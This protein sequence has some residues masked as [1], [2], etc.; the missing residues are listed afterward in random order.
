MAKIQEDII[1]SKDYEEG[2]HKFYG[3]TLCIIAALLFGLTSILAKYSYRYDATPIQI[4][5]FRITIAVPFF[6]ILLG[7]K[8]KIT[9]IPKLPRKYILY[10]A[11]AGVLGYYATM[12]F[13]FQA[14]RFIDAGLE[15][16]IFYTHPLFVIL[17]NSF[18]KRRPPSS[19]EIF[20]L[21]L[22]QIAIYLMLGNIGES[23]D[24]LKG[25]GFAFLASLVWG[26]YTILTHKVAK[27]IGSLSYLTY[28]ATFGLF[29]IATHF[30]ITEGLAGLVAPREL[31]ILLFSLAFFCTFVPY[32]VYTEGLKIIGANRASLIISAS[33]IITIILSFFILGETMT[34]LQIIGGFTV[35]GALIFL[36]R[37]VAIFNNKLINTKL[38]SKTAIIKDYKIFIGLL[39][40]YIFIVFVLVGA[41]YINLSAITDFTIFAIISTIFLVL[42][43]YWFFY[44]SI[45]P[46]VNRLIITQDRLGRLLN[47]NEKLLEH[48]KFLLSEKER[49][50]HMVLHNLKNPMSC[51]DGALMLA[52]EGVMEKEEALEMVKSSID[53]I[54]DIAN[55]LITIA[56]L[57][58][59]QLEINKQETDLE[60]LVDK[61]IESLAYTAKN[62]EVLI[63]REIDLEKLSTK[64]A[65]IDSKIF[66]RVL[67]NLLFNAIKYTY[68]K[69]N[70]YIG[71]RDSETIPNALTIYIKDEGRGIAEDQIIEAMQDLE[72]PLEENA[73]QNKGMGI[74]L[75]TIRK[76]VE[77]HGG[78]FEIHSEA[79]KGTEIRIVIHV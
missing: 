45:I 44:F 49:F 1:E 26:F 14:L 30:F 76:F 15:R 59:G 60:K 40:T 19:K 52:K 9:E 38:F 50:F 22:M 42:I 21:I 53:K 35:V 34:I 16:M 4:L 56:K 2:K 12:T 6:W 58:R 51:V 55:N 5:F 36:E 8:G 20:V 18:I 72:E 64:T 78:L 68:H 69:G 31:Y 63:V 71:L 10:S 11:I 25:I 29:F 23:K 46:T 13:C 48:E 61:T 65:Y 47:E 66:E 77:M 73:K 17:I 67:N 33:P 54:R 75:S 3:V 57:E 37:D 28:A 24:Y 43:V 79:N 70:V 41:K 74:K 39:L 62:N 7:L 27:K 32:I